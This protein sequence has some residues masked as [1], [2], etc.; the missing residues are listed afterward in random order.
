MIAE[1]TRLRRMFTDGSLNS[2]VK[3]SHWMVLREQRPGRGGD[4]RVGGQGVA[5]DQVEGQ[6]EQHRGDHQRQVPQD[7]TTTASPA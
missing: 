4:V 6:Q 5:D 2:S 3:F 7:L 1:L